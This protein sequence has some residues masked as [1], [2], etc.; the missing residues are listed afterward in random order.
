MGKR[1]DFYRSNWPRAR[2]VGAMALGG[3]SV[4]A[5][6]RERPGGVRALAVMNAITMSVWD[7]FRKERF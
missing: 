2:A 5:F 1:F 7:A 6:A 3:V 4:L